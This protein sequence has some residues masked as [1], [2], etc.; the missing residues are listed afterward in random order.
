MKYNILSFF[1]IKKFYSLALVLVLLIVIFNNTACHS[2]LSSGEQPN[3]LTIWITYNPQEYD[4]FKQIAQDFQTE[5][6]KK[7]GGSLH[8]NLQRIPYDGL[9]PRLKYACLANATPICSSSNSIKY[10]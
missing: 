1:Y 8:L 10:C 7:H 3:E 6:N 4:V 2:V 5:Y 9:M